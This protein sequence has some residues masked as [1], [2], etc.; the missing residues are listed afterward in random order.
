MKDISVTFKGNSEAAEP[1]R[2]CNIFDTHAHYTD[3]R[4]DPDREAL[5]E[6]LPG[7][8]VALALTCGSSLP[9]SRRALA[10]AQRYPYIYAACGTHPHEAKQE[11]GFRREE[12]GALRDL[13]SDPRCVALGEIGLDYHYDFSPR[14]AQRDCFRRQL[15]I[16][17]ELDMPVIVHDREAHEDT[18]RILRE[19]LPPDPSL[20][21]PRMGVV[22]CFS[23]SAEFAREILAL[24]LHIGLG[25]AVTFKNARKPLEV[26]A[27]IP[28]ER[29]LLETDTPYM[30]PEPLRGRRCESWHI[31]YT[32]EKIAQARG[33][34]PQTLIDTC[35]ANGRK[36]FGI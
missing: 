16:A 24:G 12:A 7:R 31:A 20:L 4:F 3:R 19:F 26:A 30:A 36:L 5:L 28:L 29:L 21:T 33:I 15:E 1:H 25:G 23:G 9:D 8:G 27:Q 10:L 6:S 34:D 32:A 17:Q 11:S 14:E 13:L 22:H 2:R 18:L 35:N